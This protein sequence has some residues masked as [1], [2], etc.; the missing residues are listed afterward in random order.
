M[1]IL[2]DKDDF[3]FN[4]TAVTISEARRVLKDWKKGL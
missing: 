2:K 1:E 3:D 4:E